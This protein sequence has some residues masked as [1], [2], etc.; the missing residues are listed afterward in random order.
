MRPA[1][2]LLA[3][4]AMSAAALFGGEAKPERGVYFA[5]HFGNWYERASDAEIAEYLRELKYW[6][7][8]EVGAWFDMH[9]V[10]GMD[11]P[12]AKK[13]LDRIKF[14]FETAREL[15][16]DRDLLFLANESFAGS[17]E[18]LR[19]D[20]RPG[21]NGYVAEL[22]GHYHVE[23][24]PS[25]PGGTG[26]ILEYR[27]AVLDAFADASPTRFT[28]FPYDQGG[29]TCD[30]CAPWGA[31]GYLR[32]AKELSA[33]VRSRFP[34]AEINLSTWRFDRFGDLGEW[35]HVLDNA[36][37][38]GTIADRMY[39]EAED[40]GKMD[41]NPF[42]PY[43]S[44]SEISMHGMLPWGGF[45]AN[46]QPARLSGEIA[47]HPGALGLRPY[48]EGIYEDVNKAIVLAIMSGMAADADEAL[49]L[50][51]KRYFR[52]DEPADFI[53]AMKLLEE[54]LGHSAFFVT[55]CGNFDFYAFDRVDFSKP[56]TLCLAA[57]SLDRARAE[58]AAALLRGLEEKMPDEARHSWR[59]RVLRLRAE[60]DLKIAAGGGVDAITPETTELMRIYKA[61]DGTIECLVPPRLVT[62][63]CNPMP[64]PD[65]PAGLLCRSLP[66][67][68]EAGWG[69]KTGKVEQF[70]EL[71]DPSLYCEDG[72]W[73]VYPSADA[74]WRSAD[75]GGT[76]EHLPQGLSGANGEGEDML[77]YAPTIVKFRGRYLATGASG[78]A[79]SAPTPAGPWQDIGR[80]QVSHTGDPMYF[81]DDDG[82]LYYY[83]GCSPTNGI[84]GCE[85]DGDDPT[86]PLSE[87]KKLVAFEPD[88]CPWELSGE[89]PD[90]R[91][92]WL[93]GAWM[94]K[95]G[96]RY[97]LTY[98]ASGTGWPGYAM[99]AAYGDSPLGPF[100]KDPDNPF[101]ATREGL[102]TGTGHGSVVKG[103]DGGYWVAY[104]IYVGAN[105][106]FERMIGFDR[107]G[108]DAASG[109]LTKGSA[110]SVPQWLPKY[111]AGE[112][113]WKAL[114]LKPDLPGADAICDGRI[115]Q[116]FTLTG[117]PSQIE[118]E[119]SSENTLRAFR[120]IWRD[121]GL[122]L[123]RGV[124]QGPYRYR[125]DFL[126]GDGWKTLADASGNETDLFIDYRETMP[127]TT[128]RLRLCVL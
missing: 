86:K 114:D 10:A 2:S 100:R 19:A 21:K 118:F 11:D 20:W 53:E 123:A 43:F 16:L 26:L 49:A 92:G 81:A 107:I 47:A 103:P 84:W 52:L 117:V 9:D 91:V 15:G 102:V 127:A 34:G 50:Y 73:Y 30:G 126:S 66:N 124:K 70:R 113:G 40:L 63:F 58:R 59:W 128:S 5:T 67:G 74:C 29:C 33:M 78:R 55:G 94:V 32:L 23:I 14:I 111:G 122:D 96:G 116:F 44:M 77:H 125:I 80:V 119:L 108:Y 82:R 39:V 121:I 71:A 13:R 27:S 112:R 98:S 75:G 109:R 28:I 64:L 88:Q 17:P 3:V 37:E 95:I 61:D 89:Q 101:F 83:C 72:I 56:W 12:R 48:S 31:N 110:T 105:H 76:W 25:K 79:F 22:S 85:M 106:N 1:I 57:P 90:E 42:M 35:S 41:R 45:G 87:L 8:N 36:G 120:L 62:T 18:E 104:C 65:Y 51:A 6:G 38:I 115:D 93:E 46:P 60:I 7:C 4:V 24:C 54:N 68:S 99:G 69:W 97:I